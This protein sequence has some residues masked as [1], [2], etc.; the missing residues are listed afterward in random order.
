MLYFP[1]KAFFGNMEVRNIVNSSD[2][3]WLLAVIF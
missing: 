1:S 3:Q 2:D